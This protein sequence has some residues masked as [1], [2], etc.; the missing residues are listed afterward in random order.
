MTKSMTPD[1]IRD[2]LDRAV[3]EGRVPGILTEVRRDEQHRFTTSGVAD[4]ASGRPRLP[5]HRFRIGSTTKTFVATVLL[6]LVGEGLLGLEDRVQRWLPNVVRGNGNDGAAITVRHLLNH[7]SG[8]FDYTDDLEVLNSY[9]THTPALLV[10][11]ALAHPPV[12]AAGTGWRYSNTNYI[13][14]GMLIE[15][16]TGGSLHDALHRHLIG[17]LGLTSTSLPHGGDPTIEGAHS[18]HYTTLFD[19]SPDAAIHDA[20]E[21]DVSMF[22]AAG[23][24]ISTTGDL[25]RFFAA[26]LG[27]QLLHPREQTEMMR[28]VPT[29]EWIEHT[30]YGLGICSVTLPTGVTVWGMGGALFGSWSYAYGTRDGRHFLVANVNGDWAH[31]GW[32]DPIGIF[33]DLLRAEFE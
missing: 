27:G 9:R 4:T 28:T 13:L 24:M 20:T 8:L 5:H 18:R 32:Q 21:L 2:V 3:R 33:T 1:L 22:G 30:G 25:H 16:V 23:A 26:L 7:T 29:Q 14:A 12:F 11:I 19:P 31:G 15:A 10:E 6:R 17:P